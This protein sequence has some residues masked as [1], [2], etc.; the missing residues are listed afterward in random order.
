M[1]KPSFT[2]HC[3]SQLE[4]LTRVLSNLSGEKG[5]ISHKETFKINSVFVDCDRYCS[6]APMGPPVG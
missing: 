5:I 3:E 6:S 1:S 4:T 2:L